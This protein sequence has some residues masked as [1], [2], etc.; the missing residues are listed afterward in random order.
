MSVAALIP[1]LGFL[2]LL[3]SS[4]IV[5]VWLCRRSRKLKKQLETCH[6][7]SVPTGCQEVYEEGY[8]SS[9]KD[10]AAR[11]NVSLP[12]MEKNVAYRDVSSNW[13]SDSATA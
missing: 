4:I 2:A 9:I 8:Y 3:I 12:H 13:T 5:I 10:I 1:S 7:S 6:N 11:E